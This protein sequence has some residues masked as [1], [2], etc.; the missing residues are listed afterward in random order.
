MK[1]DVSKIFVKV[2]SLDDEELVPTL[3]DAIIKADK[4]ENLHFGVYLHYKD[5]QSLEVLM[6]NLKELKKEG[7][8]F[9]ILTAELVNI[10]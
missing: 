6:D 4:P 10:Y 2:C 7:S 9:T 3:Y 5:K 8:K 1:V